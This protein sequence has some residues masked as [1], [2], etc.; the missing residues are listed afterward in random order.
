VA[1]SKEQIKR[2]PRYPIG[3][4][5]TAE[6]KR[7]IYSHYSLPFKA[8][9][10]RTYFE[11]EQICIQTADFVAEENTVVIDPSLALRQKYGRRSEVPLRK[12]WN[13]DGVVLVLVPTILRDDQRDA[14]CVRVM[15]LIGRL[16]PPHLAPLRPTLCHLHRTVIGQ[17]EATRSRG[18]THLLPR[19]VLTCRR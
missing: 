7:R 16:H 8:T 6:Q 3:R 14:R 2:S 11:V 5:L 13:D 18:S 17:M 4:E 9:I 15:G 19:C 1:F 10:G 12:R